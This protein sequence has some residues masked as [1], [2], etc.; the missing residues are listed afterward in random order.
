[1]RKSRFTDEQIRTV[2]AQ[3][4][5]GVGVPELCR[6]Y[7]VSLA[8]FYRWREKYGALGKTELQRL[9]ELERESAAHREFKRG[10]VYVR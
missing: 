6:K 1:M 3:A 7:G 9:K 10:E 2:V 8:T 5:A 4:E